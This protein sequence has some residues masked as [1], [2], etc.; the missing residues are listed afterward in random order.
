MEDTKSLMQLILAEVREN[1]KETRA[2]LKEARDKHEKLEGEVVGLRVDFAALKAKTGL[3]GA[4]SGVASG[5][6]IPLIKYFLGK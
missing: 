1:R 4:L 5:G 6:G 3:I 2:A